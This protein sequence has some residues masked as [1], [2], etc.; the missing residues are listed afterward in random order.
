MIVE[1]PNNQIGV[2]LQQQGKGLAVEFL[3]SSLPEGLRRQLDVVTLAPH[4]NGDHY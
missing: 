2:D 3:R 4:S 1:L